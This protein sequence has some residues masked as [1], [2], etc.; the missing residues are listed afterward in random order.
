MEQRLIRLEEKLDKLINEIVSMK[1]MY[2]GH[3]PRDKPMSITDAAEYLRL[4]ASSV[5]KLIYAG[6]LT[7]LQRIKGGRILFTTEELNSFLNK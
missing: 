5:Y 1:M 7:P 2:S 3:L 6:K 4:S